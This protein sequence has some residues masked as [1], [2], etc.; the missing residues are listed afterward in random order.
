MAELANPTLAMGIK[1]GVPTTLTNPFELMTNFA[2]AQRSMVEA[3][4][5][6]QMLAARQRAGQIISASPDLDTAVQNM[7][8]DP[9]TSG[10]ASDVM[11]TLQGISST[12]TGQK[13]QEQS[14]SASK[15]SQAGAQQE[16]N[17]S[18]LQTMMKIIG[19]SGPAEVQNNVDAVLAG[20]S[21][22]ARA[23]NEKAYGSILKSLT[24]GLDDPNMSLQDKKALYAKRAAAVAIGG[25]V[26]PD[27]IRAQA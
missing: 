16:Q 18:G 20:M 7:M 12:I 5:A 6:R 11:N 4:S 3:Q 22:A 26:T 9:L 13:A 25:N 2:N 23:A 15:T 19:T 14:I 17:L 21:P 8:K 1:T 10:Y 27:V 24:D